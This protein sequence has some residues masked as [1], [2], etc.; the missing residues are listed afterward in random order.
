M[1]NGAIKNEPAAEPPQLSELERLKME[2]FALKY[3]TLQHQ[4]QSVVTERTALIKQIEAD[5][6]GCTWD[7]QRGLVHA[8]GQNSPSGEQAA[9]A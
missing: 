2:N 7:E 3:Q 5:H 4:M 1:K 9:T 6:P 8:E